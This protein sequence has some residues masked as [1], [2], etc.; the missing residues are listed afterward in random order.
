MAV[1]LLGGIVTVFEAGASTGDAWKVTLSALYSEID[2]C[3]GIAA[4]AGSSLREMTPSPGA[5]PR[6]W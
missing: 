3:P 5:V 2:G 1:W 6:T 4:R